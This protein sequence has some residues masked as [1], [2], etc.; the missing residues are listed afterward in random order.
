M[1]SSYKLEVDVFSAGSQG[2][3]DQGW[4]GGRTATRKKME[5]DIGL[6]DVWDLGWMEGRIATRRRM[7]RKRREKYVFM[8][9]F[10]SHQPKLGSQCCVVLQVK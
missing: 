2:V 7:E 1:Y 5:R 4:M 8:C 6:Q 9:T 3:W 10:S